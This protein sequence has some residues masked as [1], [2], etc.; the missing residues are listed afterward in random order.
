MQNL[1]SSGYDMITMFE[2]TP[3]LVCIADKAGYFK[4]VN[5]S[6]YQKLEYSREEIID[7][8][9]SGFIHPEDRDKT[10][11]TRNELLNGKVLTNFQNRYITKT[12]KIVWLEW[13]SVYLTDRE[14][15]FAI[16]K[17]VT[18]KKEAELKVEEK[19]KQFQGLA[20]YFKTSLEKEK[21]YLAVTL[22]EELA[23]LATVLKIDIAW[24]RQHLTDLPE[25]PKE[26]LEHAAQLTSLLIDGIRKITYSMGSNMLDDLGLNETLK[27]VCQ[28]FALLNGIHCNY[29]CNFD[30]IH[31]SQEIQLDFYRICQ[32]SLTNILYHADATIV[33]VKLE[34]NETQIYL[35]ISDN[36]NGFDLQEISFGSGI[37]SMQQRVA[38]VHGEI[39]IQSEQGNGTQV[40]I[41]IPYAHPN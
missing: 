19:F 9:V 4:N 22:H 27:W 38:S 32:E 24:L 25:A 18:E 8:L 21:K 31:L 13:T 35:N 14:L 33:N 15:V 39:N 6:V 7:H 30:T 17:D 41:L 2:M 10:R 16:A 37:T 5:K 1:I 12:G 28:E 34:A 40:S 23:Q 26:K 11:K 20:T 36:G 3:D 29:E